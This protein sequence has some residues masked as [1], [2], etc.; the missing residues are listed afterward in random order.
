ME[1]RPKRRRDKEDP[2][3]IL[4]KDSNY[5]VKFKD[6]NGVDKIVEVTKEVFDCFNEFELKYV[7]EMNEFDRHIEHY[8]LDEYSLEKRNIRIEPTLEELYENKCEMQN[9][10]KIIWLLPQIQRNRVIKNFMYS[11]SLKDIAEEENCSYQSVQK[12]VKIA[13]EKMK[14]QLEKHK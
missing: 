3:T 14:I 4:K 13:L 11:K 2:Y 12:S 9:L 1:N 8:Q 7:S 10:Y 6:V 5:Y